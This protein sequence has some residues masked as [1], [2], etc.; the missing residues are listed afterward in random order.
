MFF[1]AVFA[2]AIT[3]SFIPVF[4]EYM[5]K[6][7]KNEAYAFSGNFITVIGLVSVVLALLAAGGFALYRFLFSTGGEEGGVGR[8]PANYLIGRESIFQ[9]IAPLTAAP[10]SYT[11]LP[12][13][14]KHIFGDSSIAKDMCPLDYIVFPKPSVD[15]QY[16]RC[17]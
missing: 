6:K 5:V 3:A 1:D 4:N 14:L 16:N 7:G 8:Y 13:A 10:V 9:R 11:H 2:S 15:K 12:S 17:V